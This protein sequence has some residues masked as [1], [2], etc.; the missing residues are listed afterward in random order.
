MKSHAQALKAKGIVSLQ[1]KS[2]GLLVQR[3]LTLWENAESMKEY[4]RSGSHLQAMK[5]F[6]TLA[7]KSF[8][9]V[10]EVQVPPTWDDAL[11]QLKRS[12]R[13]HG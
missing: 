5:A 3:T 6:P 4:V 2:N 9:A 12:N 13:E 8:T 1:V 7:N 10:F 11:A